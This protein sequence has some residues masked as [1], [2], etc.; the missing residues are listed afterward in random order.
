MKIAGFPAKIREPVSTPPGALAGHAERSGESRIFSQLRS[1][2]PFRMT[3]KIGFGIG[4][5]A[6]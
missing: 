5:G 2:T 3:G 1:F 6:M 4:S